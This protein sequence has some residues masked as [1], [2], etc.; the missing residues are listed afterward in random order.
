MLVLNIV[1]VVLILGAFGVAHTWLGMR[2]RDKA[3]EVNRLQE[4]VQRTE[5]E[6]RRLGLDIGQRSSNGALISQM[7]TLGVK[8]Q[9]IKPGASE[10]VTLQLD[11]NLPTA[12]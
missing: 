10:I 9:L 11:P 7:D 12:K 4:M 6:I 2:Q 5:N 8:L 3:K 1:L